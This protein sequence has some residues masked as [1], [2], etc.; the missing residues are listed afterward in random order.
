[1]KPLT[2]CVLALPVLF[3]LYLLHP[4]LGFAGL[5]AGFG[6]VLKQRL[7]SLDERGPY[8]NGRGVTTLS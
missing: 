3:A 2:Q 4:V 7:T 8:T 6:Y 1:M 5:L